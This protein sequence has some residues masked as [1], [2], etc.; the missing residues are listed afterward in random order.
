MKK[1]LLSHSGLLNFNDALYLFLASPRFAYSSLRD[2]LLRKKRVSFPRSLVLHLTD[3][4]N[5]SCPMC[6]IGAV[7]KLRLKAGF[8][9]MPIEIIN[10]LA[11][12]ARPY[13][14]MVNLYGGEPLLYHHL[15]EALYLLKQNHL[16][17]YLLTNGLLVEK[18]ADSLISGGLNIIQI[19]LD[20]WDENSQYKR[21]NVT[22]S[23]DTIIKG[24]EKLLVK[25]GKKPFPIIRIATVVTQNNFHSLDRIQQ[26]IYKLG[27]NQWIIR[28]YHFVTNDVLKRHEIFKKS[29]GIGDFIM[30]DRIGDKRYLSKE[31][32]IELKASLD[33]V[34]VLQQKLGMKISYNWDLDLERYYSFSMPTSQSSCSM[35]TRVD[36]HAD[37]GIMLCMEGYKIGSLLTQTLQEAW[38]GDNSQ[39]FYST[40]K[41]V[42]VMPM[43]FRC[44]GISDSMVFEEVGKSEA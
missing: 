30:G 31:E 6:H 24:I 23:F 5:F 29:T 3:N 15:D 7:R 9:D 39:R 11:K 4:C 37:G 43:C 2:K 38:R 21:G 36:I 26:T 41:S 33:R 10:K 19:S 12:E 44:C 32:V 14:A 13:G 35:L 27:V 8:Q 20:G 17:S 1:P 16:L 42:G 40:Y 34:R 28:H 25:K 18:K 22:G